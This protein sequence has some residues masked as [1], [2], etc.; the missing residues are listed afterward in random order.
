MT[1][2]GQYIEKLQADIDIGRKTD[3]KINASYQK[4]ALAFAA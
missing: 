2:Q 4:P 3:Q 1:R